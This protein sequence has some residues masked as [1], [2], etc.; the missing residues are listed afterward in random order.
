M[1]SPDLPQLPLS[2]AHVHSQGDFCADLQIVS[3]EWPVSLYTAD[4]LRAVQLAA[5]R[6]GMEAAA[7]VCIE[8]GRMASSLDGESFYIATGQCAAAIRRAAEGKTNG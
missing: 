2:V 3:G 7:K 4:Q 8:Q 6:A 1:T 5:Y